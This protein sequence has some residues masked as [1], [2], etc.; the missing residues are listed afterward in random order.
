MT[1]FI[2]LCRKDICACVY[3]DRAARRYVISRACH[4]ERL[5]HAGDAVYFGRPERMY[6]EDASHTIAPA[7]TEGRST[8]PANKVAFGRAVTT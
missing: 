5:D 6:A 7:N 1:S 4:V 2:R 8:V 3:T